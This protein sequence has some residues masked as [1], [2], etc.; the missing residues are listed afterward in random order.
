VLTVRLRNE[1]EVRRRHEDF[2]AEND[3]Q[4]GL[5]LDLSGHV[6]RQHVANHPQFTP[7]TGAL[8]RATNYRVIRTSGGKL[9]KLTNTRPYADAIDQGAAPHEIVP[10]A[11]NY[12][13]FVVGGRTIF[14]QRVKHPGNR[15]YKFMF[16]AHSAAN[17]FFRQDMTDR[18]AALALRF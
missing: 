1:R 3:R 4:I 7:R 6:A 17:R 2:I 12:L 10:V 5:A 18:M 11:R 9:L 13:R 16:R 8:Q 15:P 14:A